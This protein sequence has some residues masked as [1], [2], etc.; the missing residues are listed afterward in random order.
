MTPPV[1]PEILTGFLAEATGYLPLARDGIARFRVAPDV[2]DAL[3]EPYRLL[4]TIG[5]VASLIG[6]TGLSHVA[7]QLEE[8]VE[9]L[10]HGH[11]PP[12]PAAFDGLAAGLEAIEVYLNSVK[13]DTPPD[14]TLVRDTVAALRRLRGLP[15]T[16]DTS[17]T[18][19]V[20]PAPNFDAFDTVTDLP[21]VAAFDTTPDGAL[22]IP[23]FT[24]PAET[25]P[26]PAP[27]HSPE[28]HKPT[29][30]SD[31][32]PELLEVFRL[33]AEDHLRVL[34]SVLPLARKQT[35]GK[36]EWAEVRRAAHTLKG[37]AAM[38][39]FADV[40]TLAHRMEDLLDLYFDDGKA[41]TPDEIDL[42][43][44]ATDAIEDAVAGRPAAFAPLLARF[45]SLNGTRQA[46]PQP[47][48][49][50]TTVAVPAAPSPEPAEE[51]PATRRETGETFVRV[52]LEKLNDIVKLVGELVISR[53]AFEQRLGDFRR[54]L[55]ELE[56]SAARLRRASGRLDAGFESI[57]LAGS[58]SV[59]VGGGGFAD[60]FYGQG[61]DGFDALEFDRYTEF[62]LVSRE[63]AETTTDIQ[64]LGGELGHLHADFDGHLTRQSR[65]GS[66]IED[67]LMRLRMVPL[68]T[69]AAR[70]SRTV[71]NAAEQTGKKAELAFVG[72]RTGLDKAVLEAMNDP[73]LHLLRNAV[74]HGLESP[75]VRRALGKPE[76]GT[77][78]LK[79]AHDAGQV[80]LTIRDDGRGI[81]PE[82]VREVAVERGL[83]TAE[84]AAGLPDDRLYDLLFTPGFS[85]KRQVSELSGRGVG[86]DVVRTKV[87]ALKGTVGV[88]SAPGRGTT[89]TVRLPM[90]LAV[91][92]A[93]LV[94]ANR[95]TFAVPLDAVEQIFRLE[96]DTADRI[97]GEPVVKVG[98][99]V[100]PLAPLGRLLDLKTP[101]DEVA[102]PP[103][104]LV[105]AGDKR[106]AVVV[107]HLIGGREV[108]IKNLGS[109]LKRVPG[110]AGATFLG[111]GSVVLILNPAEFVKRAE[112]APAF[113]SPVATAAVPTARAKGR[114]VLLVDDSP[115]VRRVLTTL[116]ERNGWTAVS[117]KD[118]LEALEI[119]QGGRVQ[120][121]AMLTDVEMPRMDGYELLATV[122]GLPATK[123]LPVVVITSRSADKHRQRAMDLGASAYVT[124]P[125]QEDALVELVNQL[126]ARR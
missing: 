42:L 47:A 74:D 20:M 39:G 50:D 114:T 12:E 48:G 125:Y 113:K 79:A 23:D 89:F 56:P 55:G 119:L 19:D 117:A 73:L 72:E 121:D 27:A 36:D 58:R 38:V 53:T 109:H 31:I 52:P 54:L 100:Y 106:L 7:H 24:L 86:L 94:T 118:G 97:G 28:P 3:E 32:P 64:T 101:A 10:T 35:I 69:A 90:T 62:H 45:A 87:E 123:S 37:A 82:R 122:R 71:R 95:Q 4:H 68:G 96:D 126:T 9:E 13:A 5:G 15:P 67:K 108:V 116:A 25:L 43:L 102:R 84:A 46:V 21:T 99:N 18:G 40:T 80:V 70:L 78:T 22:P 103:V 65:L 8:V 124:K 63:L 105:R 61:G 77:V 30:T 107:D 2:P 17:A 16:D 120:P 75:E 11:M 92:R 29:A 57:A 49:A 6:L 115:S 66:E 93:L 112:G 88:T 51:K 85:T 110:V 34:T 91:T 60:T 81:D 44:A 76:A 26:I 111:D 98:E 59:G 1:D 41:S 104:L 83:L 33:E 14:D